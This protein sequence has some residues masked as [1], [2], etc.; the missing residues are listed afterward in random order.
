MADKIN[1][2]FQIWVQPAGF[3]ATA[4]TQQKLIVHYK[5]LK[6]LFLIMAAFPRYWP[7]GQTI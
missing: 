7:L 5:R 4:F 1:K 3:F 6:P 2:G